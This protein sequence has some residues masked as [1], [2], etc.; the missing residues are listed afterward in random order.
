MCSALRFAKRRACHSRLQEHLGLQERLPGSPTLARC[1]VRGVPAREARTCI[2][3]RLYTFHE[4][5]GVRSLVDPAPGVRLT[6]AKADNRYND[7][8]APDSFPRLRAQEA[9]ATA[10]KRQLK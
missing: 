4:V 8:N 7:S 1:H 5:V 2:V 9:G 6:L 3:H 10:S